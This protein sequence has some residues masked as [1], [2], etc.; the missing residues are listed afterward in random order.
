MANQSTRSFEEHD[1]LR[2]NL[3]ATEF[4][5]MIFVIETDS[6]KFRRLCGRE[7]LNGVERV[8]TP[9]LSRLSEQVGRECVNPV[10]LDQPICCA[11]ILQKPAQSHLADAH[12]PKTSHME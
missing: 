4:G 7:K 10:A 3:G 2:W 11:V 1:R 5:H 6:D 9:R 12:N 8:G